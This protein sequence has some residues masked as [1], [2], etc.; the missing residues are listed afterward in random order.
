MFA[1]S[2]RNLVLVGLASVLVAVA[3]IVVSQAGG[4]AA[5]TT[6][7]ARGD[8]TTKEAVMQALEGTR[9]DF[10][11]RKTPHLAGYE[12]ISGEAVH[13]RSHIQFMVE[14][15][16]AGPFSKMHG[17]GEANPQPGI[18]RFGLHEEGTIVGNIVYKTE[19]SAPGY[20]GRGYELE[21]DKAETDMK[22]TVGVALDELFASK[23]VPEG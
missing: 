13:G 10:R 19:S 9:Y 12:V 7:Q 15:R 1:R 5:E 22:I 11:Y 21:W 2:R 3:V 6:P 20:P 14:I 16:L 17:A 4:S 18:L 8:T 23:F